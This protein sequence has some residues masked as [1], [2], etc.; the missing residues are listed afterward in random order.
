M[1]KIFFNDRYIAI[2]SVYEECFSSPTAIV[3]TLQPNTN[4]EKFIRYFE[5]NQNLKELW[6]Y[7]GDEREESVFSRFCAAFKLIEAAGGLVQNKNNE[8]LMIFRFQH[9]DLP[10]GWIEPGENAKTAAIREVEEE[11]GISGLSSP[12]ALTT[13]YHTYYQNN[14]PILK[15]THWF[16]LSCSKEQQPIPQLEEG[17]EKAEWVP[18]SKLS[19]Q[20]QCAFASVREVFKAADI[21]GEAQ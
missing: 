7:T 14:A 18:L 10:K 21:A 9:W 20:L 17:I 15:C 12:S 19:N 4:I 5:A 1:Y 16:K 6:L 3:H 11:C 13:T 2:S 8:V